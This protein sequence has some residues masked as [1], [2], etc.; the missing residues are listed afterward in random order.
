MIRRVLSSAIVFLA[1][2]CACVAQGMFEPGNASAPKYGLPGPIC[3]TDL[4][5]LMTPEPYSSGDQ[6]NGFVFGWSFAKHCFTIEPPKLLIG[7]GNLPAD[8]PLTQSVFVFLDG[9]IGSGGGTGFRAGA[10]YTPGGV[11]MVWGIYTFLTGGTA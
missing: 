3:A 5:N 4:N 10:Q 1:L 6:H 8:T 7:P 9:A 2:T 11:Y